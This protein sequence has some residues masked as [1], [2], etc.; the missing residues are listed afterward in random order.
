[1]RKLLLM[2][3]CVC[4]VAD[5][6]GQ[7]QE[8]VA[9][10][11]KLD[12]VD[13]LGKRKFQDIGTTRTD[14]D[15][16]VLRES[17]ANSIADILSQ[18]TS[19]FI[20]SYGRGTLAT[21]S[22]RGTAPS[23]TQV[24]W[25]G[26]KINSPMLGQVDFS[27]IP[28]YFVD[29]MS[30][31]HGASSVNVTGGGLGGAITLNTKPMERT[32][33]ELHFI[34]GVS[35][36][37]TYD[38]YLQFRYAARKWQSSTRFSYT[39]AKN[40]FKYRNIFKPNLSED[41]SLSEETVTERNR[42]SAYRDLHFLQEFYYDRGDG[43]KFSLAA[44]WMDSKRGIPMLMSNQRDESEAKNQQKESSLRLVGNWEH[45]REKWKT[46]GRVGYHYD[47]ILYTYD[48]LV[49]TSEMA[50]I[51]N[52]RS[53]V[54]TGFAQGRVQYFL[55][56][57]LMFTGDVTANFHH[58]DSWDQIKDEGFNKGRAEISGLLT[59]RYR[60]WK[61]VGFAVDLREEYA[62]KFT[63]VI[64][65]AFVDVVLWEPASLILKGSVARNYRY[66]TLNDL[67]F[68]PGGND[69][70]RC[71]KGITYD[72][73][74]EFTL[75]WGNAFSFKGEVSG[76]DSRIDDWILWLPT[77]KGYWT[78]KN[79]K[80]VH[81]YGWELKGSATVKQGDWTLWLDGQW[82]QTRSINQGDPVDW[83]DASI[84]KQLV[85]IP[86][87]SSSVMGKLDW[88]GFALIYKY[89]YFSRRFT[90]SSNET[91]TK[92]SRLTPYYMNDVSLEKRFSLGVTG[93]SLKFTVYNLF[94]EEYISVL[95]R[96][97][98]RRN[99]G[100]FIGIHPRW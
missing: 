97:M 76:Y 23:H 42:N 63:P 59:A 82:A 35:S 38:E 62:A 31:W 29:D 22:F 24:L 98:A 12:G 68:L 78:P 53:A 72:G 26:M 80:K 55:S 73:G 79:V 75:K 45:Y 15:T 86:E 21:A 89:N 11:L 37:R 27:L 94:N 7:K 87:Y 91:L 65:A 17:V 58:V 57:K 77:Y 5:L 66:P 64:P 100:F 9:W 47:R 20:K 83:A 52:S 48:A 16:V 74:I 30:L 1:M 84:G 34:Q 32:G 14:I 90:T 2:M 8:K 96:P 61:R 70:L 44:W 25:N 85:Y 41:G 33:A 95:G 51:V 93:L 88:K 40:D 99:Y 46:E 39:N 13:V 18:N 92:I 50:Q 54:H 6:C 36:F 43:N 69:S 60:P 28:S 3:V 19:I 67:Y 49:G 4:L 81:S 10:K 71:E 56:E